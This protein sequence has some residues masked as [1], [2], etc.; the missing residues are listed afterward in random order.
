[1]GKTDPLL[2]VGVSSVSSRPVSLHVPFFL[3][4]QPRQIRRLKITLKSQSSSPQLT[5]GE[6][7][8][9]QCVPTVILDPQPGKSHIT[10]G[11][12]RGFIVGGRATI[13]G[14]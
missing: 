13:L 5:R 2:A 8:P 4:S 12:L 1:M 6:G 10:L 11:L 7:G 9:R 3:P 14:S